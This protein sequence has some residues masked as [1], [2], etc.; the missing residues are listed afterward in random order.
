M[1]KIRI[2]KVIAESGLC[3]RRKADE[4]ILQKRVSIN[5]KTVISLST[6]VD[7]QKDLIEVDGQKLKIESKIYILL[8]KPAGFVSTT[9]DEKNRKTV[10]DL[11]KTK[12]RIYP[13][14]R[15][16]FDTT[17]VLILTNDGNFANLL[18]HPKNNVPRVYK[19]TLNKEADLITLKRLEQGINLDN[20]KAKFENIY[21]VAKNDK[22][23]FWV[24]CVEGRNHFVKNMFLKIGY[25]VIK[26]HRKSFSIF[27]DDI[28]IGTY[29]FISEKEISKVN[30][31]YE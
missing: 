14:G 7:K 29:R 28:P 18:L 24:E 20:K 5:G 22:F 19:V 3:S 17:G 1:N 6:F 30:S 11:I 15:L 16:D 23:S 12:H 8:N 27:T 25:K 10:L 31:L 26:L 4:L 2:N 13:V 9:S 21:P